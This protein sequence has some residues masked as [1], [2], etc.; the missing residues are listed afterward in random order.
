M[1]AILEEIQ[2]VGQHG[3]TQS[4]LDREKV[5]L[6]S[7]I[8]SAYKERDQVHSSTLANSYVDHFNWGTPYPGLDAEWELYQEVL[9]QISLSEFVEIAE[10]WTASEDTGL[11]IVRPEETMDSS[12]ADLTAAVQQQLQTA[13]QLAVE[14][15]EDSLGDVPLLATIPTPGTITAEEQIESI[16]AQMWTLS[17]GITVI[18]KQTDFKDDEVLM[19]AFSP[20]GHSLVADEDFVSAQYAAQMVSGSGVGPHDNV[21]LEKLLAGKLVSVSPFIRELS[22]GFSGSASPEDMETLFQLIW[23]YATEPRLDES[24]F[25]RYVSQ[26]ISVAEYY[27]AEPD[28]I[29]FDTVRTILDQDHLRARPLTVEL[30]EELNMDRAQAVY[31]DRFS[32]LGD[33]TFVF[34]GAFDWD[35]LRSLSETYLASLPT[36]GRAEQWVDHDVDP[37]S[38]LID[39]VVNAG[40]EPRSNTI[41]VFAGD[42]DWS[43][44]E[45]LALNVAG[46]ILGLRLHERVREQ[47]GG[48]YGVFVNARAER[49]PDQEYL[50]Q[51]IFGSDPSRTDELFAEVIDEINWLRDGGEQEYLDTVK[52]QLRSNREEQ[53]RQNNFWLT[54]I[55]SAEQTMMPW[56]IPRPSLNDWTP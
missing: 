15:Y 25:S 8:D 20:G 44:D 10:I 26:L 40:T 28:S 7:F 34:V 19:G 23:L 22:E 55:Q 50:A 5:N 29:L 6:L 37:P 41:V 27:A 53:L 3:F 21:T 47:L 48:T 42:M 39:D 18:A 2:R 32:D 17:N 45:A 52:E 24:V 35:N 4:E 30:V 1:A 13:N 54:L 11:L 49:L 38:E 31:A 12:D 14:P 36:A 46:E 33:A 43:P 56:R 51:I 16:D 9:P